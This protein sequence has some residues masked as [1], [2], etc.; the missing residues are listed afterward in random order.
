M[1]NLSRTSS[2]LKVREI[3]MSRLEHFAFT[4]I[5]MAMMSNGIMRF[6]DKIYFCQEC[7]IE[8]HRYYERDS[9]KYCS[10]CFKEK[11]VKNRRNKKI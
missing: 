11:Y 3:E 6:D 5:A 4:A 2:S 10:K 8:F 7:E 9:K 1:S